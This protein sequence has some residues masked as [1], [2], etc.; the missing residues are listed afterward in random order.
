VNKPNLVD[1]GAY[2]LISGETIHIPLSWARLRKAL[3]VYYFAPFTW[4]CVRDS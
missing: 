1:M 2:T 4:P 3:H